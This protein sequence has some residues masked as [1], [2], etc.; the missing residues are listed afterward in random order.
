MKGNL[1]KQ[2]GV[3]LLLFLMII[4]AVIFIVFGIS[5]TK[6][7][8]LK[9]ED[10]KENSLVL[11]WEAKGKPNGYVIYQKDVVL[12]EFK[13]IGRID[14]SEITD[15]K[16]EDLEQAQQYDFMVKAYK[17][18]AKKVWES[19]T[20]GE[21]ST[22]TLPDP[23][24]ITSAVY[25]DDGNIELIWQENESADGYKIECSKS[26]DFKKP[27]TVSAEKSET[28]H[29]F[30]K[31]DS[32]S[33][34]YFRVRCIVSRDGTEVCGEWSNTADIISFDDFKLSETVD[35]DKPMIALTFDD[36]P[37]YNDA[38]DRILD[39]L[40]KYH[41][42]A[43]F[44]MVGTNA[45]SHKKNLQRKV[46]LGCELGNHTYSHT[47]Y[48][49]KI[50]AKDIKDC[51][52]AIYKTCGKYPTCFRSP[53]GQTTKEIREVCKAENMP[54]YFWSVDT[55]DWKF[56]DAKKVYNHVMNTAKDGDIVLM[57]EI[58]GTTAD[59]VEKIVP[60][61]IAEGY[62]LVTVSELVKAKTGNP[63]V[64]GQEYI[65]AQRIKAS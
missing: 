33:G 31:L 56:R 39:V 49:S 48:G 32:D 16:I 51:S 47:K 34:Y 21:V 35:P 20:G 9:A 22:C 60:E 52:E 65:T 43:T 29:I 2:Y 8:G 17:S 7:S 45:E 41:A 38:S 54:I 24:N 46:E 3:G 37:G 27:L 28:K 36:G 30:D 63:P 4:A 42:K 58:Y 55:N 6:V 64:A 11:H 13:E 10:I 19:K 26:A 5:E 25:V 14:D 12:N 57:H 50:T 44:F 53:G 18:T 23:V 61:L 15:F 62:Q 1:K 59:A 40:E